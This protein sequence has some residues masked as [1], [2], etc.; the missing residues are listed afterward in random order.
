[1]ILFLNKRDLFAEKIKVVDLKVCFPEYTHGK[2]YNKAVQFI[3]DK[4][5]A[6]NQSPNKVIYPH[7]TCATDTGKIYV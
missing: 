4:F 7:V 2:D 5:M 6:Q 3:Q 1:M